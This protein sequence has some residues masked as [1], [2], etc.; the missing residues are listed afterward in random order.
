[1]VDTPFNLFYQE[2]MPDRWVPY[3]RYPRKLIRKLLYATG[4]RRR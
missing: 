2:P 3:D 4:V 1:M